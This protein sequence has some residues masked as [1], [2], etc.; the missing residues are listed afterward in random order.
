MITALHGAIHLRKATM[1]KAAGG[2]GII[3]GCCFRHLNYKK[4]AKIFNP[5]GA[6]TLSL[7]INFLTPLGVI[8]L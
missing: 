5:A 2:L 4:D 3:N 1:N 8:Y 7:S 6:R